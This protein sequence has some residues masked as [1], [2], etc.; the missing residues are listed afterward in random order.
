MRE[1]KK[2]D[3]FLVSSE[4]ESLFIQKQYTLSAEQILV[5]GQPRNDLLCDGTQKKGTSSTKLILYAPTFRDTTITTLFPFADKDLLEL[6]RF[7][8]EIDTKIMVRLHINEEK[9]YTASGEYDNLQNIFFAGSDK[10]PSVNE[11]LHW[12]D[13]MITDYSSICLDYLL[14]NRPIAY[15]P[16]DFELYEKERGFS[17]DYYKHLAGKPLSSQAELK[18][19]LELKE[20]TFAEKRTELKNLFHHYQDGRA[21]ERLYNVI[22]NL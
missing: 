17:F 14:L 1:A 8:G 15:I 3:Y 11:I 13:G 6:D 18:V 4:F 22:N 21:A 9:V 5:V 12:F 2:W 19:F 16:Y 20:D 7:L 10:H